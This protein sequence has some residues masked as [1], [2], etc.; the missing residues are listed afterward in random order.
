M[1]LFDEHTWC[2]AHPG[3]RALTGRESSELQWQT[4]AALAV[5]A[6]GR[7]EALLEAAAARF[8]ADRRGSILVLNPSGHARTDLVEVFCPRSRVDRERPLAVV[9]VERGERVPHA[10][11]RPEPSRNRP[12]G[13][14]LSFVAHDVPG[15]GY[16]SFEL[17]EDGAHEPE[18]KPGA[19]ENEHYRL[20]LDVDGGHAVRVLDRELGLDLVDAESAFGVGQVVR[21]LYGGPLQATRRAPRGPAAVTYAEGRA[22]A[23]LITARSTPADGVVRERVS[24]AVEER[25]TIRSHAAGFDSI[26]TSFRLVHGIRRID[27]SVRLAKQATTAKEGIHVVFPFAARHPEVAYELTGGV[28]GASCVPGSAAHVHAIRHWVALQDA[29]VTIAWATLQSPL[30]QL[31]NIFLPY[32]PYPETVDCAGR[33]LVSS[34]VT[35]N[36]WDTNFPPAQGGE[37]R[38]DYAIAS[39]EPGADARALAIAT[40]DTLTRPLVG[41]LGATARAAAGSVCELDAPGVEVVMLERSAGGVSVHLQ[42]YATGAVEVRL[43]SRELRVAPEDYVTVPLDLRDGA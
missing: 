1:A 17:V 4:K 30:V 27:V 14:T 40:A 15:L 9:D 2:A 22:S 20:E 8:R 38:F 21:D 7:A 12:Q 25:V 39:A 18:G 10:F 29:A 28:G 31:G 26:E 16:R 19:L 6:C 42:S 35:N 23:T 41:V 37:L 3:G 13:R 36:V 11:G 32:P 33:G 34:W 43:G 24:S 5:E